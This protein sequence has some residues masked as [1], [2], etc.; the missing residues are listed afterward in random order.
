MSPLDSPGKLYKYRYHCLLLW[1]GLFSLFPSSKGLQIISFSGSKNKNKKYKN[2]Q[3]LPLNK[4]HDSDWTILT[5]R[6]SA[7][8]WALHI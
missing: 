2:L 5:A 1:A 7:V 6:H 3:T 8:E 4:W